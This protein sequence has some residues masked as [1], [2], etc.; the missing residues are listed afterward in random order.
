MAIDVNQLL[1]SFFFA[2]GQGASG[3][4]RMTDYL[5]KQMQA[6]QI[7]NAYRA[8]PYPKTLGEGLTALGQSIGDVAAEKRIAA[9]AEAYRKQRDA[10]SANP[11]ALK[12]ATPAPLPNRAPVP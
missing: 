10:D 5:I 9:M 7:A 1:P 3:D 4:P 8:Q 12:A 2:G 6:K 11:P